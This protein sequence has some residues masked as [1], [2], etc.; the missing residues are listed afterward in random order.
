MGR[1]GLMAITIAAVI[2]VVVGASLTAALLR[3]D[4][5]AGAGSG[6]GHGAHAE[7]M[8]TDEKGMEMGEHKTAGHPEGHGGENK[9][10]PAGPAHA[11]D[12][13]GGAG[14]P[15]GVQERAMPSTA[16]SAADMLEPLLTGSRPAEKEP[17]RHPEPAAKGGEHQH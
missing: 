14:K 12:G 5:E 8:K 9:D 3:H 17:V 11:H 13:A 6:H 2:V 4:G 16:P 7:G 1:T 15:Q 10:Q